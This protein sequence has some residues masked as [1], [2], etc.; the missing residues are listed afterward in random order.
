M[1][2]TANPAHPS[3]IKSAEL[4]ASGTDCGTGGGVANEVAVTM[5]ME[6]TIRAM[7]NFDFCI[8]FII[9]FARLN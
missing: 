8:F 2:T 9:T 1:R 4:P 3:D 7:D 5:T 6:R